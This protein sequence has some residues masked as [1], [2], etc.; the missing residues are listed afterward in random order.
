[1]EHNGVVRPELMGRYT[2]IGIVPVIFGAYPTCTRTAGSTQFKYILPESAGRWEWPWRLLLD[3]NPGLPI[4]WHIDYGPNHSLN[5]MYIL[6]GFLT[7]DAISEEDGSRCVAP[8]WLKEGAIRAEEALPIMTVGSA[9]ALF[10]EDEVGS[11]EPG[12]LAD[13]II[14]S[15]DPLHAET[16]AV[17]DIQVLM[18]M[19]GGKV[20]YCATGR[21]TLCPS[22][23]PSGPTPAPAP[24]E[25]SAAVTASAELPDTPASN[26]LDGNP[27]TIWN[28]GQDPEQWIMI[29]LGTA[30]T[31]SSIRLSISQYPEGDT[32]HQIWAGADPNALTL[33][34]EFAGFTSDPGVLGFVPPSP[35]GGVQFVKILTTRSTSWVAWREIEI[36]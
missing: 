28:S 15:A 22:G 4:A 11:L 12:K 23:T 14:L 26:V 33:M 30:Q 35:L 27:E 8:D 36:R 18:T 7:R 17:K 13:L 5:P 29:N 1:M 2:E 9:Y 32:V 10:M 34:H 3:A 24:A 6:W 25:S 19:I 20:E 21:E 31:V 16:D